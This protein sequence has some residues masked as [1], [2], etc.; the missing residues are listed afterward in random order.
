V[1]TARQRIAQ[2]G[3]DFA[4][5]HLRRLGYEILDRNYRTRH[6]EL[7]VVA[8][9]GDRLVFVEV[10]ARRAGGGRPFDSLHDRKCQQVR[11]MAVAWFNE[12]PDHPRTR[13]VRF[14]AIGVVVDAAG[15]LVALDHLEAAF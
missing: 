10:K 6:G 9:D 7:D 12:R 14:D 1:T 2:L 13:E 4:C 5:G 15:R 8:Y 3:E 11:S